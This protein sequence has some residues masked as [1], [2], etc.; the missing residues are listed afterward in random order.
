MALNKGEKAEIVSK[1]AAN[2]NDTGSSAVQIA[3]LTTRINQLNEH[4]R[5]HKHD[6]GSRSGLLKLVG[7]RR[8]LLKYVQGQSPE[9]YRDLLAKL[10]LRK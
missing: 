5:T 4:L 7:K 8:S 9:T 10:G 6:Q 3:I 1:F 2:A